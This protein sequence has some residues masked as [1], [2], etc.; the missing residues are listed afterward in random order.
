M[1]GKLKFHWTGAGWYMR[2]EDEYIPAG[3]TITEH[4]AQLEMPMSEYEKVMHLPALEYYEQPPMDSG[5]V[6][7]VGG[8]NADHPDR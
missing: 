5:V 2:C 1:K 3:R 8:M 6:V 7:E 4:A